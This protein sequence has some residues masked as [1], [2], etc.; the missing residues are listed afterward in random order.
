[1][2]QRTS[3]RSDTDCHA[4]RRRTDG[5]NADAVSSSV[6][7]ARPYQYVHAHGNAAADRYSD[8]GAGAGP[9]AYSDAAPDGHTRA[10]IYADAASDGYA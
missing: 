9:D 1:M 5:A 4:S 3:A 2:R 7:D 6:A 8:P 10:D